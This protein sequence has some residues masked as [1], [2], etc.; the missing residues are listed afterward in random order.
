MHA[1]NRRGQKVVC[2]ADIQ[3]ICAVCGPAKVPEK[4]G[5]YT[6]TDF[7]NFDT[8]GLPKMTAKEIC[9]PGIHLAEVPDI[10]SCPCDAPGMVTPMVPLPWPLMLFKPVFEGKT[11]ISEI[12]RNGLDVPAA[13]RILETVS[14]DEF[15]EFVASHWWGG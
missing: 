7:G 4:N 5:V 11:D 1:I 9:I 6:V 13:D 12:V 15:S 14:Q 2:I 8:R 3:V 10:A